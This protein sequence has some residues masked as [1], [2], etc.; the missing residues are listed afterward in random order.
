MCIS[1]KILS[2]FS[3]QEALKYIGMQWKKS[4]LFF[5]EKCVFRVCSTS[6]VTVETRFHTY[7][8]GQNSRCKE[9][10]SKLPFLVAVGFFIC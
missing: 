2:I 1:L 5:N 6:R 3:S 7:T 10:L 9:E 4:V 8:Y